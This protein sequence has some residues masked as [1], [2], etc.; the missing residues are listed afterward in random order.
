MRRLAVA[1][2][3]AALSSAAL[4][5][6]IAIKVSGDIIV[7]DYPGTAEQA[8]NAVANAC[9]ERA[10]KIGP[11]TPYALECIAPYSN[12]YLFPNSDEIAR[13]NLV[14]NGGTTRVQ[15][16]GV[17]VVRNNFGAVRESPGL[18]RD[19]VV[20][21]L[22]EIGAKL[23]GAHYAGRDLGFRGYDLL[24]Y[25]VLSV[26]AT[27]LAADAGLQ[28]KDVIERINGKRIEDGDGL[29]RQ[30]AKVATGQPI[31]F[32][33]NRGGTKVNLSMIA[34]EPIAHD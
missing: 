3:V 19:S 26:R 25:V 4:A 23:Q 1:F 21:L 20:Y 34:P 2:A 24:G 30:I 12:L 5:D 7:A 9:L 31:A 8:G 10:W 13:F 17:F 33:V 15:G 29:R 16:E 18:L 22:D 11:R 14:D 32:I 6:P 28:P 27:S